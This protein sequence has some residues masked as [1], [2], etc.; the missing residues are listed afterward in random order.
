[1]G[2][3]NNRTADDYRRHLIELLPRG[4]AWQVE[5]GSMM[6]HFV[7]GLAQEF[8]RLDARA[9]DMLLES[10]ARETVEMLAEWEAVV[11]LPD[12][13]TG[14]L[15]GMAARRRAVVAKL[16][17]VGGQTPAYFLSILKGMGYHDATIEEPFGGL[18][19][20]DHCNGGLW[21]EGSVFV[22][23]VSIPATAD[24]E[25]MTCNDDC[26]SYLSTY[27]NRAVECMLTRSKP[28]HTSI[29]FDYQ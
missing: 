4:A 16:A 8:A 3:L 12:M 5:H 13:C 19:C 18:S 20:N 24:F 21:D 26:N 22:W 1:M 25:M 17:A 28:S 7:D 14:S 23:V 6:W 9:V 29:L 10:F 2:R 15:E 11:G 27:G